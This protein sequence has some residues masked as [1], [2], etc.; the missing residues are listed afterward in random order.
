MKN[1]IFTLFIVLIVF[2]LTGC[3]LTE[4]HLNM[5][6]AGNKGEGKASLLAGI[7][8]IGLYA[9]Y[10]ID[11]HLVVLANASTSQ[12]HTDGPPIVFTNGDIGAGYYQ[13][14]SKYGRFEVLGG[15]GYGSMSCDGVTYQESNFNNYQ[16]ISVQGNMIHFFGQADIG[17]VTENIELGFGLRVSNLNFS[18]NSSYTNMDSGKVLNKM[19]YQIEGSPLYFE[20]CFMLAVGVSSVK[21]HLS[22]G[23]S[24]ALNSIDNLSLYGLYSPTFYVTTGI[25]VN[26]FRQ[27]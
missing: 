3:A 12:T 2:S 25:T 13:K 4:G 17:M 20:P 18:G 26:I 7:D 27:L 19:A 21:L 8:G 5:P 6:L 22:V 15:G 23:G 10:C 24:F 1:S 14:I 16:Q 11:S 9:S